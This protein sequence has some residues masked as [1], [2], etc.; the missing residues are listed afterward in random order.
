MISKNSCEN[1]RHA[2]QGYVHNIAIF[3]VLCLPAFLL[4][5]HA[6]PADAQVNLA[7]NGSANVNPPANCVSYFNSQ[8]SASTVIDGMQGQV[9]APEVWGARV[10]L[11]EWVI[12]FF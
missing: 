10:M 2:N 3:V 9:C 6:L 7:N 4:N 11:S 8:T 1:K 12:C 5:A